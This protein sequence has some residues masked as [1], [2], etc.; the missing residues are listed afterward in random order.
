L[1]A[2]K[3]R[4]GPFYNTRQTSVSFLYSIGASSGFISKQTGDSIKTLE[5]NYA[6]YIE[7]AD[8]KRNFVETEIKKA[9]PRRNPS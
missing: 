5:A 3:I 6:K 9:K 1:T 8:R 4:P 2:K 7:E